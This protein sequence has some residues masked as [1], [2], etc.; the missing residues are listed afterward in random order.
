ML[1]LYNTPHLLN[2]KTK[3]CHI[4]LSKCVFLQRETW[5]CRRTLFDSTQHCIG[6]QLTLG[7]AI[8]TRRL[9][10]LLPYGE[11]NSVTFYRHDRASSSQ[12][13]YLLTLQLPWHAELLNMTLLLY[14]AARIDLDICAVCFKRACYSTGYTRHTNALGQIRWPHHFIYSIMVLI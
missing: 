8:A 10:I 4:S 11:L 2:E 6:T 3:T 13:F 5:S 1:L 14:C 12:Q 7:V 9:E